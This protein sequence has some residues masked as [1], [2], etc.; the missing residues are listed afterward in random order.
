MQNISKYIVELL[1]LNDCVVIPELGGFITNYK[2][3]I[4]ST[5]K[6]TF[7]P[8]SK[9]L[10]F[11]RNIQTNDGLLITTIQNKENISY[12]DAELLT[13]KFVNNISSKLKSKKIFQID[14]IGTLFIDNNN[15]L[16]FSSDLDFN[17][18]TD[19]YGLE[20]FHFPQ[21]EKVEAV[22][23]VK[24]KFQNKES[25]KQTINHPVTKRALVGLPLLLI[26]LMIPFKSNI[27]KNNFFEQ[28]N[29]LYNL[30]PA[31][32]VNLD[33]P[34]QINDVVDN[35]GKKENA[36]LYIEPTSETENSIKETEILID[37]EKPIVENDVIIEVNNL[38]SET[39]Q[40]NITDKYF[41]IAG[42][43]VE[44]YRAEKFCK[45][46]KAKGYTPTILERKNGR[47]RVSIE[48][49]SIHADAENALN[50][51][52]KNSELSLWILTQ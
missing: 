42:S 16:C 27:I 25:I 51:Y 23:L 2:S 8:P 17:L 50:N 41:I 40:L 48:S 35:I 46:I 11:N 49:F 14:N 38:K 36:L 26:L 15:N 34:N 19:S 24:E 22:K 29:I 28:A 6:N 32:D 39:P 21:I 4:I 18:L 10:I 12:S 31:Y 37:E 9:E 43:F 13:R 5:D 30:Q 7:V 52:R 47:L 45:E 20:R 44:T 1:Y 33:N 3:A